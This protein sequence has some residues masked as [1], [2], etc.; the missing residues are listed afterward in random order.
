MYQN[1]IGL[2]EAYNNQVAIPKKLEPINAE[3]VKPDD[4]S[5]IEFPCRVTIIGNQTY[6]K[7]PLAGV[8]D[9]AIMEYQYFL[10]LIA[11]YLPS[12]LASKSD[13]K[14][15]LQDKGSSLIYEISDFMMM[16][17]PH[18]RVAYY[19][20]SNYFN[21]QKAV[22]TYANEVINALGFFPVRISLEVLK[23]MELFS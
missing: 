19:Q 23:S 3:I 7:F 4:S 13:F 12:E 9:Q 22:T 16:T 6:G 20:S 2:V 17:L 14:K 18:P 15:F 1:L 5:V 10:P 11:N 21:I 8:D